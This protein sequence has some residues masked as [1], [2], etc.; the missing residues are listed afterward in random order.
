MLDKSR[1]DQA[2]NKVCVVR[3]NVENSDKFSLTCLGVDEKIDK[4]TLTYFHFI[5]FYEE[6][7]LKKTFAAEH[8]LA[9][10][11]EDRIL[12]GSYLAYREIP[13]VG[14]TGKLLAEEIYNVLEE[15][16]STNSLTALL[17]DNTSENTGTN[18]A[19][20]VVLEKIL[21]RNLHCIGCSLHQN[22]LPSRAM[23]KKFYGETAGSKSFNGP[24]AQKCA[25]NIHLIPPVQFNLI[26]TNINADFCKN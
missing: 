6:F 7:I 26:K 10:T 24:L 5:N 15:F 11:K 23:F 19:L 17:V 3:E 14:A 4:D 12:P 13:L 8:H 2:K 18:S 16:N 1:L 25:E 9:F 21:G 22:K 20:V